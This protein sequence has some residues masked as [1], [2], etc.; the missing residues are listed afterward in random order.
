MENI[1][2]PANDQYTIGD[3]KLFRF[4][5]FDKSNKMM[6]TYNDINSDLSKCDKP[7][8]IILAKHLDIKKYNSFKKNELYEMIKPHII[9]K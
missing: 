7:T 4:K 5:S 9:F 1:I 8:L 3:L 2:I 6:I